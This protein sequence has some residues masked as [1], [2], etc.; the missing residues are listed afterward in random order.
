[1]RGSEELAIVRSHI[2]PSLLYRAELTIGPVAKRFG[3]G[4]KGACICVSDFKGRPL[5]VSYLGDPAEAEV[6]Q[7]W[8]FAQ[9]KAKR[10][11]AHPAHNR[12]WDSRDPNNKKYGG[13]VR[14]HFVIISISGLPE[15][16]DEAFALGLLAGQGL[17]SDAR[18][19]EIRK[20]SKNELIAPVFAVMRRAID[21]LNQPT[22]KGSWFT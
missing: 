10:L 6:D 11:S 15:A 9:E 20:I 2:L 13:A 16:V 5:L 1:M 4:K 22:M 14:G 8:N 7:I 3:D 12:S 17:I 21:K 18:I 19:Q